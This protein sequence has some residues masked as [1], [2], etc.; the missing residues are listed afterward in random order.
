MS[1]PVRILLSEAA[2]RHLSATGENAFLVAGRGSWPDQPDRW[3]LWL[4]PCP[5]K[6]A[7]DAVRV[8]RG[9]ARAVRIKQSPTVEF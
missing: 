6:A 7:N 3:R 9:E 8:A 5:V 2:S 4:V 1:E